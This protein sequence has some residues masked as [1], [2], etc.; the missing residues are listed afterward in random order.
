MRRTFPTL[1][2]KNVIRLG[3]NVLM[4]C[5]LMSV[6]NAIAR[7]TFV[8]ATHHGSTGGAPDTITAQVCSGTSINLDLNT[9][10]EVTDTPG[11]AVTYYWDTTFHNPR[12]STDTFYAPGVYASPLDVITSLS[13]VTGVA[14][15]YTSTSGLSGY[16]RSSGLIV[17]AISGS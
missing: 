8:N 14:P 6:S 2:L 12:T 15:I 16:S 4:V 7:P 5:L 1:R 9:L 13:R 10:L 3:T 11:H 17:P